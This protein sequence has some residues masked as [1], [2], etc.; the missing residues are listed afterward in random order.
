MKKNK[1]K[2]TIKFKFKI[3]VKRMMGFHIELNG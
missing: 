3:K 1:C 2:A